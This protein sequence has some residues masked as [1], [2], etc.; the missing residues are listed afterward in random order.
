MVDMFLLG[1]LAFYDAPK[2]E[3]FVNF[4]IQ[5]VIMTSFTLQNLQSYYPSNIEVLLHYNQ[6]L[7]HRNKNLPTFYATI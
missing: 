5:G 4:F 6:N 1:K 7:E 3:N 2:N